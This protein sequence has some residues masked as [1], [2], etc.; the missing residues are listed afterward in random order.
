MIAMHTSA[1]LCIF[2]LII[3]K[4][5]SLLPATGVD[6][7]AKMARKLE[8]LWRFVHALEAYVAHERSLGEIARTPAPHVSI[9][10]TY[11][12]RIWTFIR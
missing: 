2:R 3:S 7:M 10:I 5:V 8:M 4:E 6:P 12:D 11:R 9:H 1:E